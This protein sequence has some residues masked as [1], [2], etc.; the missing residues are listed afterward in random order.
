MRRS[1]SFGIQA[2][3]TPVPKGQRTRR[4]LLH[5]V[6]FMLFCCA[7][8]VLLSIVELPVEEAALR[9]RKERSAEAFAIVASLVQKG[10]ADPS[11]LELLRNTCDLDL[12]ELHE[13]K[14][15]VPGG[16]FFVVSI[17]TTIGYGNYVPVT[18]R[19]KVITCVISVVGVAY[20]G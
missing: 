19:G 10:H 14:W 20:C 18:P 12:S 4:L 11:A 1:S 5:F 9:A 7:C 13:P 6:G 17:V 3:A 8:G 15:R 2:G 16:F